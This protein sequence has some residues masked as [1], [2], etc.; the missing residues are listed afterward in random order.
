MPERDLDSY[1]EGIGIDVDGKDAEAHLP[2]DA[3]DAEPDLAWVRDQWAGREGRLA[4]PLEGT[5]RAE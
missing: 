2:D 5:G 3:L 4:L 1:L